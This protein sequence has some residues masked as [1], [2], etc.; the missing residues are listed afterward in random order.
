MKY[1]LK[2]EK[3]VGDRKENVD[4]ELDSQIFKNKNFVPS[5]AKFCITTEL[6][7]ANI[8]EILF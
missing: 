7:R 3:V 2:I 8:S 6:F 1:S 5:L 4:A